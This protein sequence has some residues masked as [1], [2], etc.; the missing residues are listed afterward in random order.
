M[1]V[2]NFV[3]CSTVSGTGVTG[4]SVDAKGR[5]LMAVAWCG[6]PPDGV[7]ISPNGDESK[8]GEITLLAPDLTGSMAMVDIRNPGDGWK[9]RSGSAELKPGIEYRA[10][11]WREKTRGQY[12]AVV[13]RAE[14][15][16]KLK[17][18]TVLTQ[19][20]DIKSG[21]SRDVLESPEQFEA[22]NRAGC[23]S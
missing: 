15:A 7:L 19:A 8:F 17:V 2:A 18:N 21:T 12:G 13:F 5:I 1:A 9:L 11:A 10:F 3:S 22:S 23:Q 4:I 16:G 6:R 14:V 20:Y